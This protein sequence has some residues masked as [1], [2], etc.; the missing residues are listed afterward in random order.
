MS[1]P[2]G[3]GGSGVA[4]SII[5][6]QPPH[7]VYIE[8]FLGAGAVMRAKR[9]AETNIGI[10]L[11]SAVTA[12]FSDG[13]QPWV[14]IIHGD[15]IRWL[16]SHP[17]TADTLIYADPPYPMESRKH[18]RPLYDCEMTDSQHVRLLETLLNLPCMVQI[19]TYPNALYAKLLDDWRLYTFQGW[20]RGGPQTEHLYMNYGPP[21]A[22]HDYRFLGADF[23]ERERIQRKTKRW[24][25]RIAALLPLE[26]LALMSAMAKTLSKI[27]PRQ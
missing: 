12:R 13:R 1:Y 2:G 24:T 4:Q 6:Q 16:Q 17:P 26:R 20:S 25:A 8:P 7:R 15:A 9:P 11:D 14:T 27:P 21:Q 5:N 18:A 10:D 22:L 23:R 19:S 3:K